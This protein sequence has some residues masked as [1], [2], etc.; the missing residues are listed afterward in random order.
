[1]ANLR[2]QFGVKDQILDSLESEVVQLEVEISRRIGERMALD[3]RSIRW[4]DIRDALREDEA[5]VEVITFYHRTAPPVITLHPWYMAFIITRD[6]EDHP[7]F[8]KL[9]DAEEIIPDYESYRASMESESGGP[10]ETGLY[11]RLWSKIDSA[12]E[13]KNT[14]F[15][16]P[17]G[18]FHQLN[19]E[20]LVDRENQQVL[21][22]YEIKYLNSLADLLA[23]QREYGDNRRAL[24]AGDPMFRMARASLPDP[25]H[26]EESST[27]SDFQS[28]MFPGTRLS[29]LPGTRMEID[30]IGSMLESE[31][32]DCI[33]VTGSAATEDTV[34]SVLNPRVLHLATHG[35]FA[36]D[37]RQVS[38][39][40]YNTDN[41]NYNFLDSESNSTSCLFFAGAQNTLFFAYDYVKG[42]G[43]GILTAW[44]I[45]EMELDSTELVVLSACETGLGEVY[46]SE[47]VAGLRR[48]FHLAGAKRI[49]LSLWAVND[50]ATQLLMREF[51][52]KWLS[53]LDMDKAL[54]QAKKY[55]M[56]ETEYSHPRYWAG[57]IISGI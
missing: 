21:D 26:I 48:A 14:I 40:V 31:G 38:D 11:D 47:G 9:F 15:F 55:L 45:M 13:G 29:D 30:S 49:L 7:L 44:E 42:S 22:K 10:L 50:K 27:G 54:F 12:L 20:A 56:T 19:M 57:F 3:V 37:T 52:S 4:Q 51:Y 2:S 53:G 5:A 23:E 25:A 17:D 39:T 18:L 1:M 41:R 28:R 8:L 35:F 46:N 24:L 32:W 36:Q 6:M 43:D 34:L 16:S 33:T